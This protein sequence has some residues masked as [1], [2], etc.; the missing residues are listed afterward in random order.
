MDW[1]VSHQDDDVITTAKHLAKDA[2]YKERRFVNG[3]NLRPYIYMSDGEIL[4]CNA[5]KLRI[6]LNETR[7]GLTAQLYYN[8]DGQVVIN[9]E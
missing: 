8:I 3:K 9:F 2:K 5:L 7:L 6:Y 4:E 1:T